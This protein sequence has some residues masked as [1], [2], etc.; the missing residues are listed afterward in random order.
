MWKEK[1]KGDCESWN[2]GTQ[3]RMRNGNKRQEITNNKQKVL[4]YIDQSTHT[5]LAIQLS[6]RVCEFFSSSIVK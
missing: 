5:V 2:A 6:Y 1:Q 4:L 3:N